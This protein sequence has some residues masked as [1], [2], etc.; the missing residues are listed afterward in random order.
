MRATL[1]I[2]AKEFRGYFISPMAYVVILVFLGVSGLIF[3]LTLTMPEAV[4]NQYRGVMQSMVFITLMMAPVLTMSLLALERGRGTLELLMTRPVSD[5]SIVLGKYLAA[6]GMYA[7]VLLVTLL[8]PLLMSVGGQ[9][10]WGTV[11]SGYVGI[12]CAAMAFLAI[13][14]FGSSIPAGLG[15][16]LTHLSFI[17]TYTDFAKGVIDVRNVIYFLSLAGFF[18]FLTERVIESRRSV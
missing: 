7:C 5:W 10:E 3:V 13:G 1:S 6:V 11:L 2:A 8:F 16:V 4:T 9:V 15:D 14:I 17:E 18:V 12:L